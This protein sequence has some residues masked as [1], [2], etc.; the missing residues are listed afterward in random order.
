MQR[1]A[2][3]AADRWIR[4]Q[5]LALNLAHTDALFPPPLWNMVDRIAE[6]HGRTNNSVEVFECVLFKIVV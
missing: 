2:G 1:D 4:D 5:I 6:G 3:G